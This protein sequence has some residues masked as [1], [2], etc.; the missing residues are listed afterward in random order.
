MTTIALTVIIVYMIL[1]NVRVGESRKSSDLHSTANYENEHS[2]ISTFKDN[3][4][5]ECVNK[6]IESLIFEK[7]P[8]RKIIKKNR[9]NIM[10]LSHQTRYVT[11]G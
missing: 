11:D 3:S 5:E 8:A 1:F 9:F 2:E 6:C 4:S 7:N 10:I